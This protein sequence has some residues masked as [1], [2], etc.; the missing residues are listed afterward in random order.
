VLRSSLM[1]PSLEDTVPEPGGSKKKVRFKDFYPPEMVA[2]TSTAKDSMF[3]CKD[4]D[5]LVL[6]NPRTTPEMSSLRRFEE[7]TGFFESKTVKK[8][9]FHD[10]SG[11][12]AAVGGST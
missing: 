9:S 10:P 2:T 8:Q 7:E 1:I 3:G 12:E 6:F 11:A 4:D 5:V